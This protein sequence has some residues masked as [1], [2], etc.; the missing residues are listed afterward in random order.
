MAKQLPARVKFRKQHKGRN[1]GF[2]QKG[3]YIAFGDCAL[4]ALGRGNLS[5]SE[6]E[7]M[8]VAINRFLKRKGK[9][10]IRIFPHKPITKKPAETRMGKGKGNVEY[11]AAVV[12]PGTVICELAG[13][14]L[15]QARRAME[16]ASNKLSIPCRFI[17]L[18]ELEE[19]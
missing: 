2:A 19:Y 17:S 14:P 15:S 13:V 9:L 6:I 16:L 7:S 4:Q 11:W 3:N 5:A 18:E 8:R 12:K 1:R 10:W